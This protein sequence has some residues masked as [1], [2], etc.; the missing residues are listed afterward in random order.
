MAYIHA[1]THVQIQQHVAKPAP[2]VVHRTPPTPKRQPARP[3]VV[4]HR[5]DRD[6]H[7]EHR[8]VIVRDHYRP[9]YEPTVVIAPAP[10]YVAPA[11]VYSGTL[12]LLAPTALASSQLSI[13]APAALEAAHTLDLTNAGNGS[14]YV[15]SVI[16]VK[17]DGTQ[18]VMWVNQ[19][20]SPANP[21]V[22]LGID[23]CNVSQILVD[24]H[25]DWGGAIAMTAY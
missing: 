15:S 24:G 13:Y 1:N 19:M 18:Q 20:V 8:E 3:V 14:T 7:R 17:T 4:E 9:I 23:G 10:V 16:L 2:V 22:H 11:P 5:D 21:V 6:E 12:D 25:S